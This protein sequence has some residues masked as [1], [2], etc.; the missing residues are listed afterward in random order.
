MGAGGG[1]KSKMAD[2]VI[3]LSESDIKGACLKRKIVSENAVDDLRR[4]LLCR[5]FTS[6]KSDTKKSLCTRYLSTVILV[7]C[8]V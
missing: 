1:Q 5:G 4:W 3:E 2:F 8:V 6:N 7:V